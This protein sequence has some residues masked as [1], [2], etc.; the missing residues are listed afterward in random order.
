MPDRETCPACGGDDWGC[1]KCRPP[2]AVVTT[3]III[4]P[5]PGPTSLASYVRAEVWCERDP[6]STHRATLDQLVSYLKD[7]TKKDSAGYRPTV[8][9]ECALVLANLLINSTD[10]AAY[11]ATGASPFQAMVAM[12]STEA[13]AFANS[14]PGVKERTP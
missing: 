8:C 9:P 10:M 5:D 6:G 13:E 3:C 11:L 1:S 12:V 14:H 4:H 2:T 7:P